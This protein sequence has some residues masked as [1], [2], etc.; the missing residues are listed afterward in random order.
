M[1][2]QPIEQL[3]SRQVSVRPLPAQL[4]LTGLVISTQRDQ[5][6]YRFTSTRP[7]RRRRAVRV[8]LTALIAVLLLHLLLALLLET[9]CPH[10]R[11]PEFGHRLHQLQRLR[12][13][14]E[15]Q[16]RPLVLILGTSR[17][18]NGL[19]PAAMVFADATAAP[20]VFNAAQTGSPPLKVLL[21]LHRFLDAGTRPD[22][23][24]LEVFPPWLALGDPPEKVFANCSE[25]LSWQDIRHLEPYCD[26][27]GQLRRLWLSR[28]LACWSAQRTI[29]KSHWCPRWLPWN[30]R[31]DPFW[32]GMMPD[33]F[34]PFLYAEPTPAFRQRAIAHA[35]DEYAYAFRSIVFSPRSVKALEELTVL[36]RQHSIALAWVE[37]PTSAGFRSWFE[38]GVWEQGRQ[39]LL[40]LARQWQVPLFPADLELDDAEFIDGHH[41]LRSGAA[42]YSRWL[43]QQHLWPWWAACGL[44]DGSVTN[45]ERLA[46]C[47]KGSRQQLWQ[48]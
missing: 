8:L 48:P 36:C 28:R 30:E 38:P 35:H 46:D 39:Q 13:Q 5:T 47:V 31:L 34:M 27:P 11:D 40:A 20:L 25:R 21:T 43:A 45:F 19:Q 44:I 18:Q 2:V 29:L 1:T 41:L 33:G 23:V 7:W 16:H 24:M 10:W 14:P 4:H 22:A 9:A 26:D 6:S 12:Q 15:F 17:A 3:H 42:R 32:T 37:A